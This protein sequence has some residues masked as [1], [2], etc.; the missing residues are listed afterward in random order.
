ML[1]KLR[2][3]HDFWD[4]Q[5]YERAIPEDHLLR[6]IDE[7]IDFSF[8]EEETSD[9]YCSDNG[10]PSYAPEQLFRI[11]FVSYLYNLSDVKVVQELRY[12]LLYR[13]FCRFSLSDDT[14]DDTTLVVFR[15]RLGEERFRRLFDRVVKQ[16]MDLGLLTERRKI[17]DA[18]VIRADVALKNRVELLRQG[19]RRVIREVAARY[20]ERAAG[21]ERFS[22]SAD[23]EGLSREEIVIREE[24]FT[25]EM[26]G[27]LSDVDDDKVRFWAEEL[28]KV[29]DGE[30][31]VASFVDPDCRWGYKKKG[32]P[33]L[34]Y[35]AHVSCDGSG[36][37]TS[38]QLLAGNESEGEHM[39]ELLNEDKRKG[40]RARSVTADKAYDSAH[41]R[42]R[43]R[44][45]GM[46]P[47]IPSRHSAK[48]ARKFRYRPR[49]D[50]FL[51]SAGKETIGKTP[52][53]HGGELYYFSERDCSNCQLKETCL[54]KAETRKRVYLSERAREALVQRYEIRGALKERKK[55][56]RKFGEAKRWHRMDRS[57]YRG[58]WRVAIG[59]LMTFMVLNAKR[60]VRLIRQNA[61][62]G[63]REL[64]RATC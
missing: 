40:V 31:G 38:A 25:E 57:R 7:C 62:P 1:G 11:M 48:L 58:R 24:E 20:P 5:L 21:L 37:V 53:S 9:L 46:R 28:K 41:N 47:E 18:T 2:T 59:M 6:R 43:T 44:S 35:K 49:K 3:Q 13:Y 23:K 42:E 32:E 36:I 8:V 10:R 26:L 61:A 63:V 50:C 22:G 12:N 4:A 15:A 29:K 16:A 39:E 60:I 14:P 45:E 52:H 54:G 19:R 55:I 27:T 17:I 34:G 33:F 51:C 30:G 56:E 64:A